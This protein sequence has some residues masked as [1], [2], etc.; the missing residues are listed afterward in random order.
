MLVQPT[1]YIVTVLPDY[2]KYQDW[3]MFV[4]TLRYTGR[5]KWAVHQGAFESSSLPTVLSADGKW[6]KEGTTEREDEKWLSSHRFTLGKALE[7]AKQAA[8]GVGIYSH[9]DS[10]F[11][12]ATDLLERGPG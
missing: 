2:E 8:P 6:E 9:R 5:E 7:L 3:Y 1:R 12:T 11:I 4:V 10:K